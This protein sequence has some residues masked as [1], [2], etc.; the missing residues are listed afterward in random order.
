MRRLLSIVLL[1]V[2]GLP[3]FASAMERGQTAQLPACCRRGGAHHC[4]EMLNA[5]QSSDRP[6][7]RMT[8]PALHRPAALVQ[9]A[10][11]SLPERRSAAAWP[12]GLPAT[13]GQVE[14]GYRMS[15]GRARHK[16]GPPVENS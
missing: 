12:I 8:C 7:V 1:A 5:A 15:L 3:L 6:M 16:R 4:M 2:L 11:W 13:I 14:S 9:A 10:A